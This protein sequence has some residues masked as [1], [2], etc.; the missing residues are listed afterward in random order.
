MRQLNVAVLLLCITLVAGCSSSSIGG[1][2]GAITGVA[3]SAATAN[4]L[5]GY[6]VGVTVQAVTD[7]SVKY[8][9]R[10]WTQQQQDVMAFI[11][12]GLEVGQKAQWEVDRWFYYGN[13][14]GQLEVMRRINNPL[15]ECKEVAYSVEKA[16]HVAEQYVAAICKNNGQW[17]WAT[18]E[19]SV[20]RW[21]GLQ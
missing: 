4:P 15:V 7:A 18:V 9:F 10:T 20:F 5:I 19:P 14:Q 16:G 17:K 11:A 6:S 12:G 1:A 3:S 21:M 2:A 8:V 13:E